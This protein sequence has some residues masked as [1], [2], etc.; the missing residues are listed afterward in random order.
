MNLQRID[1]SEWADA[2]P[3]SGFEVFHTPE[4]LAV[5]GRHADGE[6]QLYAGYNG[7][8]PVALLPIVVQNRAAGSAALSPPPALGIPRL[9]PLLMPASPKRRKRERLNRQFTDELLEALGA[10]DRW[11]LFRTICSP[12]YPDP[13]PYTWAGFDVEPAFTYSLDTAGRSTDDLLKSFSKS[14][15]REI[16]DGRELDVTVGVEPV[17]E[18]RSVYED[19]ATR[20]RE[21]GTRF[22]LD[23]PYV[24]DL[25][26][27][28]AATDRCR[29]YVART[30]EGAFLSGI[31]V[32]Y[33]NDA[34]YFWQGGTRTT[35][36]GVSINSLLHWR[37]IEDLV[38]APPRESVTRYD[39][40]GANTER[41]CRYKSKFGADLQPYYVVET[42]S[43]YMDVAKR[44]YELVSR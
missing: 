1:E 24:R 36:E 14:L 42:D 35:H 32:L 16:R 43:R 5:V 17:E 26:N 8:R 27:A 23:W 9:G 22:A 29:V 10:R 19:T 2:L 7:D 31:T 30:P 12:T 18:V 34:A 3:D 20:Y 33:S 41:L 13:R 44:A 25:T 38:E 11:T 4:A 15:R 40:M 37:I 6:L 28:L 21:Q 39:L